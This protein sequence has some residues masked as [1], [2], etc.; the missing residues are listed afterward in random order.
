MMGRKD[1]T[2]RQGAPTWWGARVRVCR[3]GMRARKAA[4]AD[5]GT[6]DGSLQGS[7]WHTLPALPSRSVRSVVHPCATSGYYLGFRD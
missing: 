7:A 5:A 2:S 6:R 3:K 1:G 4:T